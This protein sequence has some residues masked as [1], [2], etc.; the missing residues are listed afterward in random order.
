MG[1]T[2]IALQGFD[3]IAA[4]AGEVKEPERVIPRA[5]FISL[6]IALL[7]YLPLL[8]LLLPLAFLMAKILWPLAP[9]NPKPSLPL[10]PRTI[11]GSL[12]TGW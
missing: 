10:P 1:Y 4:V 9:L 2:F 7:I 6:G 8:L 3:L 12:V 11:W 5:M